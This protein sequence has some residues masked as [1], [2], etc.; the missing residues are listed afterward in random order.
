[1]L[2]TKKNPHRRP[3][4]LA[5]EYS[6]IHSFANDSLQINESIVNDFVGCG[7]AGEKDSSNFLKSIDLSPKRRQQPKNQISP[8]CVMNKPSNMTPKA[9][10]QP[11]PNRLEPV[12]L[13]KKDSFNYQKRPEPEVLNPIT[14]NL[15]R[16]DTA[17]TTISREYLGKSVSKEQIENLESKISVLE[18]QISSI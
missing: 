6:H 4:V 3:V 13:A 8:F 7:L 10:K 2:I 15:D 12:L 9:G 17:S 16:K 18:Q 5:N 1:M 14:L 11:S